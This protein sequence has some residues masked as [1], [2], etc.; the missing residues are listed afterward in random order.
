VSSRSRRS[1]APSSSGTPAR[2]RRRLDRLSADLDLDRERARGWALSQT[3][4]W[5]FDSEYQPS[6]AEILL[7]AADGQLSLAGALAPGGLGL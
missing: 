5:S 6:H 2:V 1:S 7:R 3:I 4:A